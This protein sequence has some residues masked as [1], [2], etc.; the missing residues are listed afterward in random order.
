MTIT[1]PDTEWPLDP[2]LD[3]LERLSNSVVELIE[4]GRLGEAERACLELRRRHPDLID[5]IDRT[6]LLHEARGDVSQAVEHYR[7]CIIFIEGNPDDF[8]AES[9]DYYRLAI[10]RLQSRQAR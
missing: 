9:K 5:W 2:E 4:D 1:D 7:L 10:E 8:D 3:E 6:G